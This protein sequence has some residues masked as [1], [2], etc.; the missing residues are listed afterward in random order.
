MNAPDRTDPSGVV[1]VSYAG[2]R[3]LPAPREAIVMM[4][5]ITAHR[6]AMA[7]TAV[8]VTSTAGPPTAVVSERRPRSSGAWTIIDRNPNAAP[9]PAPTLAPKRI[10]SASDAGSIGS[11]S[12]SSTTST[13]ATT[14]CS[15]TGAGT[16][17]ATAGCS[18]GAGVGAVTGGGAASRTAVAVAAMGP[19]P[20][21]AANTSSTATP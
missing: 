13:A 20:D 3:N 2:D 9:H 17:S 15:T 11:S 14:G 7:A 16:G 10:R 5:P 18:A 21:Q 19:A 1:S 4:A 8:H 6:T 12:S